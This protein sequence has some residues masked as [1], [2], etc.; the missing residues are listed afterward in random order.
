[1]AKRRGHGEG[2]IYQLP[3]G[4]WRA[5][6]SLGWRETKGGQLIWRRKIVIGKTRYE[7]Q[8]ELKKLLRDQQRGIN[9]DPEKQTVQEFLEHWLEQ[10][11][12]P[13]VR[14]ATYASYDWIVK[15]HLVPG[16]GRIRLAKLSPQAV[17]TFLNELLESGRLPRPWEKKESEGQQDKPQPEPGLTP[18]TVQHIHATLRTALDQAVKWDLTPRNVAM[19][20]DAPRVRRSEVKPFTPEQARKFLE[21][22]RQDRLEGLYAVAML[23]LRQGEILGLRWTDIDFATATLAVQQSLQ[24]VGGKLSV[25]DTKTDRSR[26]SVRLPQVTLAALVRHQGRQEQERQLAG[27][28]WKE[29]SFVFTT[30]VGTPMDGPTVTH[31]FQSL[32]KKVA[33]PRMRFH[34]LR[35]TCAT[36]LLAQGVHPRIVMEILGHSQISITM[37]LYSH[38]IPAMQ[39][40]VAARLDAILAPP[41]PDGFATSFAT[42]APTDPVN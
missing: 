8:E 9:I 29:S 13:R 21:A 12:K 39:Q 31:R 37:N 6:V 3:D 34:D 27:T 15:K 10:V 28:R 19:L 41:A 22:A 33:L 38:V 24:R 1:M 35:H 23:G 14:A 42:N 18:R 30:T 32:L 4:R 11:A 17:Q 2:S 25:V 20:V 26:R 40:E 16:L 7:V 36:L 5:A